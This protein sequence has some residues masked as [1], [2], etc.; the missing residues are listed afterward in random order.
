MQ[1][2]QDLTLNQVKNPFI[3]LKTQ[4]KH[5]NGFKK[6]VMTSRKSGTYFK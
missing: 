2:L 4:N 5:G 1:F 3:E 6:H